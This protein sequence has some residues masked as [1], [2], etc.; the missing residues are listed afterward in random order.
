MIRNANATLRFSG[1]R[2]SSTLIRPGT[3]RRIASNCF[4]TY[5]AVGAA[6]VIYAHRNLLLNDAP[7]VNVRPIDAFSEGSS[8]ELQTIVWGSNSSLTLL[9]DASG[10]LPVRY[11]TVAKW[12]TNVALRDV[13]LHQ[14]HGACVDARGDVYQWGEGFFGSEVA[15]DAKPTLTL[16]GKNIVQ[17]QSTASRVYALSA[18]GKVYVIS[19]AASKQALSE[20]AKSSWWGTSWLPQESQTIDF[21]RITPHVKPNY[22]E[23]FVS[24]SA[25]DDHL[26]A[27]TSAGR[28][29]AHPVSKKANSNGQLGLRRFDIPDPASRNE[30]LDVELVPA[31][32]PTQFQQASAA[33][34][35]AMRPATMSANLMDIDDSSI[36]FCPSLFEIPSLKGIQIAQLSAASRSSYARTRNGRALAW[37]ANDQGQLGLGVGAALDSVAVPTE[38]TLW[39]FTPARMDTACVDIAAGGNLACFTVERS[40]NGVLT[41]VD[42]LMCGNGQWGGLG[43]N[44]FS[45]SQLTPQ[46]AKNVSGLT[47]YNDAVQ[48]LEPVSPHSVV[49]SPTG[50]VLLT[51]ENEDARRD[52]FVWGRNQDHELGNGKKGSS[53]SPAPMS[54][55]LDDRVLLLSKTAPEV[56]DLAGRVWKKNVPVSQET[57]VGY[58]CSMV[59]W[60]VQ[61]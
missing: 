51:L 46:R 14:T 13:T 5:V 37:G 45:T 23:K 38:V 17:L 21:A 20:P 50:H 28:A 57:T 54:T 19:S 9:P 27:L 18:S 43:N 61:K 56:R 16:R 1:R 47:A 11:P 4:Y 30:R 60:K 55:V 15:E 2:F 35:P 10:V 29:F 3:T 12:L 7:Q 40:E 8:S 49:V 22:G 26:L 34:L 42:V 25:G 48:R 59:Y 39:S 33:S 53:A 24:I 31:V 36:R 58:G 44:Q 41:A 52:L 6:C 32:T